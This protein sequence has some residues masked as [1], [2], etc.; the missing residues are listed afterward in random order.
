[1][2]LKQFIN[3]F[4]FPNPDWSNLPEG[5]PFCDTSNLNKEEKGLYSGIVFAW[6]NYKKDVLQ[7]EF[8]QE[9]IMQND[10]FNHLY[11]T[12]KVLFILLIFILITGNLVNYFL[13]EVYHSIL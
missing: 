5:F 7:E 4:D 9:K 6:I 11:L 8:I 10:V 3:N 13:I 2:N 1:M 12:G